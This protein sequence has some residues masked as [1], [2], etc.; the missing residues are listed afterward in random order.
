MDD[1]RLARLLCTRICHDLAGPAGAVRNGLELLDDLSSDG[2]DEVLE[3]IRHS[4]GVT[5]RRLEFL[6]AAF[7]LPGSGC[8]LGDAPGLTKGLFEG[9]KISLDWPDT[10]PHDA[11][12]VSEAAV[13]LALN[14]VLWASETLPRGGRVSVRF[15]AA[16][17]ALELRVS[18][19]GPTVR[20]AG[21][22]SEEIAGAGDIASLDPRTVGPYLIARLAAALGGAVALHRPAVN[23]AE[24]RAVVPAPV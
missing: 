16:G 15:A 4:T 8:T 23:T 7:G 5:V 21:T 3:I 6:R 2:P 24:L 12:E 14:L 1:L 13:Q 17:D 10:A 19:T 20:I 18:A 22:A 9:G 11:P